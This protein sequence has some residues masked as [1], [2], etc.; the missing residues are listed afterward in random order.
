MRDI[1]YYRPR[2]REGGGDATPPAQ[3]QSRGTSLHGTLRGTRV[4]QPLPVPHRAPTGGHSR[5]PCVCLCVTVSSNCSWR[6][7]G[8]RIRGRHVSAAARNREE[9]ANLLPTDSHSNNI[10]GYLILGP[11]HAQ[12]AM[13]RNNTPA[14]DHGL[15]L[16]FQNFKKCTMCF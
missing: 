7:R 2:G 12:L 16:S 1:Y 6:L 15:L 4:L 14:R 10:L 13:I 9:K 3:P 11:E 5:F 8:S